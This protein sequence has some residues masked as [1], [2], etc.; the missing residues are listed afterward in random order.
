MRPAAVLAG[1]MFAVGVFVLGYDPWLV[2]AAI[3]VKA[4]TAVVVLVVA[5][6][7]LGVWSAPHR[8]DRPEEA[9]PSPHR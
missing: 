8:P 2:L 6:W 5:L 1:L 7:V 9:P 4:A 3:G